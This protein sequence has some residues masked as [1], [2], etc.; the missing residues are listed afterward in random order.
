MQKI[1]KQSDLCNLYGLSVY[2]ALQTLQHYI[3]PEQNTRVSSRGT[4]KS[5]EQVRACDFW[6]FM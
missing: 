4:G 6:L 5:T 3:V 1:D 2:F